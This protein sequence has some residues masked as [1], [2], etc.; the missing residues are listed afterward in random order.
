MIDV[1]NQTYRALTI[2]F[3]NRLGSELV[4]ILRQQDFLSRWNE[5]TLS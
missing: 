2:L 4:K 5:P 3:D 1:V